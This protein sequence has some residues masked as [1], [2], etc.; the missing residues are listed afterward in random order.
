MRKM[1]KAKMNL[2]SM[3]IEVKNCQ[4][5]LRRKRR[6]ILEAMEKTLKSQMMKII[7]KI[8]IKYSKI[9]TSLKRK[10]DKIRLERRAKMKIVLMQKTIIKKLQI[11]TQQSLTPEKEFLEIL[12]IKC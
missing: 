4:N 10:V 9:V 12:M 5:N 8:R 7:T 6:L 2:R 3:I 11:Q 1:K